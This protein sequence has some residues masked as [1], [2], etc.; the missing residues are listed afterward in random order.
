MTH[1]ISCL[2]RNGVYKDFEVPEEVYLYVRQLECY[3]KYPEESKL[4]SVYHERFKE[5]HEG[6]INKGLDLEMW[7]LDPLHE[8]LALAVFKKYENALNFYNKFLKENP[9]NEIQIRQGVL[10]G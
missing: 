1:Y 2:N 9:D 10:L 5:D 3:V 4:K 7:I 8:G 6:E